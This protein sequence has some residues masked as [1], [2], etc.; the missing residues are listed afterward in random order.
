MQA[1][2]STR[3][4]ALAALA[5]GA[6]AASGA[7][8]ARTDVHLSIGIPG[9]VYAQPAPV[10]VQPQPVYVQPAPVYAP[11]PVVYGAPVYIAPRAY[12]GHGFRDRHE[13][14]G[15]H[16]HGHGHGHGRGHG[17]R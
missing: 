14:R 6:F 11:A 12:Y 15:H 7:A 5:V 3:F 10:Y 16:G 4:L 1:S 8:Q 13:W 2:L 9:P 17:H